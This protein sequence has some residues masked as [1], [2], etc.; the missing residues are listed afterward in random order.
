MTERLTPPQ[1]RDLENLLAR[2]RISSRPLG[3]YLDEF[4]GE[5]AARREA[6]AKPVAIVC[7]QDNA[8]CTT[9]RCLDKGS[10]AAPEGPG[11]ADARAHWKG[12][13]LDP[14]CKPAPAADD[15]VERL[16]RA[17]R[18]RGGS[19][20]NWDQWIAADRIEAL[21]ARVTD[22]TTSTDELTQAA[23]DARFSIEQLE[24]AEAALAECRAKTIEECARIAKAGWLSSKRTVIGDADREAERC[25]EIEAAIRALA[26]EAKG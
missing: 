26:K 3:V 9:T 14:K 20:E 17:A 6:E 24:E 15:L 10:C 5:E 23:L 2:W 8:R 19:P 12:S 16:R 18:L 11:S 22:L 25:D 1:L 21:Q 7:P 13:T 4:I